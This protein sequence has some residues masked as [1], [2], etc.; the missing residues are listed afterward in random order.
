[1]NEKGQVVILLAIIMI[2]LIAVMGLIIDV[3][4]LYMEKAKIQTAC[5][6]AALAGALKLPDTYQADLA[7]KDYAEKNGFKNGVDDVVVSTVLNPDGS[8]PDWFRVIIQKPVK[9]FFM[10]VIGFKSS[11]VSGFAT[12]RHISMQ[13]INAWGSGTYGTTGTQSLEISGPYA[14]DYYGDPYSTI[15]TGRG[16]TKNP[17]YNPA[18]YNF[19]LNVPSNYFTING[20]YQVKLGLYDATSGSTQDENYSAHG[21][22]TYATTVYSIYAPDST[23]SD[24]SDDVLIATA[25]VLP[26]SS[27]YKLKW[28]TPS[29]FQFNYSTYGTG[30]YRVNVKTT[31]GSG[32]NTFH[33]RAGPPTTTFN[34]NNG[35]SISAVGSLQ[36]FFL[37]GGTVNPSLGYIPPEAAGMEVHI[38]KFDTDVGATSITYT[39]STGMINWTG[40]LSTDGKWKEDIYTIPTN[41]PGGVLFANYTAMK[42]DTSTWEMW[43]EGTLPGQAAKVKL[44]E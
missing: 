39:D 25:T 1:M 37:N 29:G 31:D 27:S 38:N 30:N 12:A 43:Y 8:H 9:H 5:D 22:S 18:G 35:T 16:S 2:V 28:V 21:K 36:T 41:Y 4:F 13:P 44:V 24:Y 32:G 14:Y 7:A 3:G 26:N 33:L 19:R 11:P 6:A 10:P 20:T 34:P 15:Y 17:K 42:N 40:Q 23:P